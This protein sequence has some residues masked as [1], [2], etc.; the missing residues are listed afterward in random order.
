MSL[1]WSFRKTSVVID[2]KVDRT[3]GFVS[4][5][6]SKRKGNRNS[7]R[8][9]KIINRLNSN[10]SVQYGLKIFLQEGLWGKE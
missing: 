10:F 6:E 8:L 1:R 4:I 9:Y 5:G 3:G 2:F 7:N